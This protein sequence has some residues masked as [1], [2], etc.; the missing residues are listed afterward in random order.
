MA[1][2]RP[3]RRSSSATV[4]A[5]TGSPD[6]GQ[7][8]GWRR[9]RAGGPA[10]RSRWP[11]RRA[12]PRRRWRPGDSSSAPSSDSS[13]SRLCGGH[14][15]SDVGPSTS[16]VGRAP[17]WVADLRRSVLWAIRGDRGTSWRPLW[18][19]ARRAVDKGVDGQPAVTGRALVQGIPPRA[20]ACGDLRPP[21]GQLTTSTVMGNSTSLWSF[22]GTGGCRATL[23]G[24]SRW[25][26]RRS[27]SMPV[28]AATAVDD[29]GRR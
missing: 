24:S 4:T 20:R 28:C 2:S 5:S 11:R 21:P 18:I 1:S 15:C 25:T 29:V 22:T 3:A 26:L 8:C 17:P 6:A 14:P 13:A 9:R 16:L 19:V 23:I 10:C 7:R 27:S 12:R